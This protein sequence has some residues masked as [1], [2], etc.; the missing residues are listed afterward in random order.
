[1]LFTLHT[2]TVYDL[3]LSV[4]TSSSFVSFVSYSSKSPA[5]SEVTGVRGISD[6]LAGVT[7]M[8]RVFYYKVSERGLRESTPRTNHIFFGSRGPNGQAGTSYAIML[9]GYCD[10]F[11]IQE[12]FQRLSCN[13]ECGNEVSL[14]PVLH[15]ALRN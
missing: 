14:P 3:E 7:P 4:I 1:M 8:Q 12:G 11:I 9:N 15:I 6:S 2:E 13:K 10:N 5:R